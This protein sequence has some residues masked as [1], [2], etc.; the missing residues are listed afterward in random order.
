MHNLS[1]D[2]VWIDQAGNVVGKIN[3]SGPVV[4]L[5]GIWIMST[6]ALLR[7]GPIPLSVESLSREN[8]GAG[9]RSI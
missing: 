1:C 5:N 3:G 2:E 9:L 8:Y 7:A 4:L 6:P